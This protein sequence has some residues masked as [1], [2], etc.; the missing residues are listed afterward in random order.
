MLAALVH[1]DTVR[2][3]VLAQMIARVV[4]TDRVGAVASTNVSVEDALCGGLAL[5][6][7][8][9]R[10]FRSTV[11]RDRARH[12]SVVCWWNALV[13]RVPCRLGRLWDRG[14]VLSRYAA[15]W[16]VWRGHQWSRSGFRVWQ[17][18]VNGGRGQG[19]KA[20]LLFGIHRNPCCGPSVREQAPKFVRIFSKTSCYS[21]QTS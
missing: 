19:M 2:C 3:K 10:N 5:A 4:R 21:P 6:A 17:R 13:I 20:E 14:I 11:C 7:R 1:S 15:P 9:R 16:R 8:T 18:G 12:R